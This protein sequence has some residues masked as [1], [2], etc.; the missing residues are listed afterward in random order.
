MKKNKNKNKNK[1][2]NYEDS[3]GQEEVLESMFSKFVC[4]L[5]E[6]IKTLDKKFEEKFQDLKI[7]VE[8]IKQ[9][10]EPK[11]IKNIIDENINQLSKDNC[12]INIE[13][14]EKNN[15]ENKKEN[16]NTENIIKNDIN[17]DNENNHISTQSKN[18]DKNKIYFNEAINSL[19]IKEIN[20]TNTCE[21]IKYDMNNKEDKI[22]EYKNDK[23]IYLYI[24]KYTDRTGIKRLRC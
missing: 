21:I 18:E 19:A 20:F 1:K 3:H 8:N 9:N 10:N 2:I 4:A 12:E 15:S 16:I 23:D 24:Y 13:N 17:S 22:Y 7:K 11:K 6:E 5:K 14:Q